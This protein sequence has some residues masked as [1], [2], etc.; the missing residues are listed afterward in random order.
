MRAP[1]DGYTL[2]LISA[3]NATNATL[4]ELNLDFIRDIAPVA[5][6]VRV[7]IAMVV[8]SVRPRHNGL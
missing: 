7:P 1:S 5:G 3:G 2:I 4:D 6:I 8:P